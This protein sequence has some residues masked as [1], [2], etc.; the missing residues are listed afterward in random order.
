MSL[1][2]R[3]SI[4]LQFNLYH[5]LYQGRIYTGTSHEVRDFAQ[6]PM[7]KHAVANPFSIYVPAIFNDEEFT[8]L[9]RFLQFG[10]KHRLNP[11]VLC[12]FYFVCGNRIA[13]TR[14]VC[15]NRMDTIPMA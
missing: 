14:F 4:P 3:S 13:A 11:R 9:F 12:P 2:L 10:C 6:N 8:E 5:Q 15:G 1:Y 7:E